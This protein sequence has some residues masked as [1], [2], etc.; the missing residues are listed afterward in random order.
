MKTAHRSTAPAISKIHLPPRRNGLLRRPRLIDHLHAQIERQLVAIVAPA[1]YGKTSLLLDWAHDA[2]FPVAWY[3][4]DEFDNSPHTFLTYLIESIRV[5]FPKFGTQALTALEQSADTI[6]RLQPVIRLIAN[7]MLHLSDH[8]VVVLDDYHVIENKMIGELIELLV[9]YA[10]DSCH[11]FINSRTLPHIQDQLLLRARD[12]MS[13]VGTAELRFTAPE[14]QALVEQNYGLSVSAHRAH[15]LAQITDGWITALL[16]MGQQTGWRDLV[17]GALAMP[18]TVQPV[19][20]Y[21]AEQVFSRQSE[22]MRHFLLGSCVLTPLNCEMLDQLPGLADSKHYLETLA[23]QPFF[24]TRLG[25]D[26]NLYEYHPLLREFLKTRL[27]NENPTWFEQLSLACA[28][29]YRQQGE[30]DRA[31]EIYLELGE[32]TKA[33]RVLESVAE[34][35]RKLAEISSATRWVEQLP[36]DLT[37]QSPY[38]SSLRGKINMARGLQEE[39]VV[40]FDASARMFA[41]ARDYEAAADQRVWKGTAL[42]FLGRYRES[43]TESKKVDALLKRLPRHISPTPL[44]AASLHLRGLAEYR[45]GKLAKAYLD[46]KRAR[47]LFLTT[48]DLSSL[49]NVYSDLGITARAMGHLTEAIEHYKQALALW[50]RLGH[51]SAAA[52]ALNNLGFAYLLQGKTEQAEKVLQD[53][54]AKSRQGGVLRIE[55]GVLST[56]GDLYRDLGEYPQALEF[57]R[58]RLRTSQ[59]GND[60]GLIFY[61]QLFTGEVYRRMGDVAQ[62]REWLDKAARSIEAGKSAIELG[63]WKFAQG[64]LV[65]EEGQLKS[66]TMLIGEAAKLFGQLENKSLEALAEYHLAHLHHRQGHAEEAAS[67]LIRTA[68]LVDALGY[69]HFL[70]AEGRHT[71]VTLEFASTLKQV[72]PRFKRILHRVH[73]I[74]A[75]L[76]RRAPVASPAHFLAVYTLGQEQFVVNGDAIAEIRPQ[77]RELFLFLLSRLPTGARKEELADKFWSDLSPDRADGVLGV[78]L[79]RIRKLPCPVSLV[80]GWYVLE[81]EHLWYDVQ[82]FEKGLADAKR[83]SSASLR[84]PRLKQTLDL[85]HGDYLERMESIWV[86]E[87]RA[88]LRQVYLSALISLAEAYAETSDLEAAL[89]TFQKAS[90]VESF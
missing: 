8:L 10:G 27:Q 76:L 52:N 50:E 20:D 30:W 68:K 90:Q 19:F 56:L 41:R 83:A 57:Y 73:P 28:E 14:I 47:D 31:V 34:S 53:A 7:E 85:Y 48:S 84:I 5:Q 72:G 75:P 65:A 32:T 71:H 61:S 11:L 66:G 62:A 80:N 63:Q 37:S 2:D 87:E 17:Q 54:L 58:D 25:G 40:L 24:L 42:R 33:A 22:G 35:L 69:D 13:G 82:E 89:N 79:T 4:L 46:L 88:R 64:L 38:L 23:G 29:K 36:T 16:L 78:T 45:L 51:V 18:D 21:L 6:M 9:R 3:M 39:A 77:T 15:E 12:Q 74:P 49:A 67:H 1:G 86:I 70:V 44:R 60:A 55:A 43:L 81:P 59:E 26:D